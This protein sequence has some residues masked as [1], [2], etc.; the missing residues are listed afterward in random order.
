[1][2]LNQRL[3]PVEH[4]IELACQFLETALAR[5]GLDA[6]RQIARVDDDRAVATT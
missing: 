4:S 1:M 2:P 5:G 3:V 6:R